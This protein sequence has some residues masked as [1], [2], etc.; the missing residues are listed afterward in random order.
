[1]GTTVALQE[2]SQASKTILFQDR[3][4][5]EMD[6]VLG[7]NYGKVRVLYESRPNELRFA[8]EPIRFHEAQVNSHEPGILITVRAVRAER[9]PLADFAMFLEPQATVGELDEAPQNKTFGNRKIIQNA[10]PGEMYI[11]DRLVHPKDGEEVDPKEAFYM[12]T[13]T[14][15][16]RLV[17]A[18]KTDSIRDLVVTLSNLRLVDQIAIFAEE[19]RD[20][21]RVMLLRKDTEQ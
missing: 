2:N 1:M 21:S 8:I 5:T 3:P 6:T 15:R 12:A 14:L 20:E 17:E 4:I 11:Y 16:H 10:G 19:I 9:R 7:K 13:K 18:T